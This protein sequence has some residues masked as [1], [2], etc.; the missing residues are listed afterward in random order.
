[1]ADCFKSIELGFTSVSA[2]GKVLAK[3]LLLPVTVYLAIASIIFFGNLP[4]NRIWIAEVLMVIPL[5]LVAVTTHRIVIMGAHSVPEWGINRFGWRE[6]KFTLSQIV[7][8]VFLLPVLLLVFIPYI[9]IFI[10]T[11]AGAFFVSRMSLVFPSI[12]INRKLDFKD[13]WDATKN[14]KLMMFVTVSVFPFILGV[15]EF[16][17][18][19]IQESAFV[20]Q[21]LSF[22]ATIYV[23][24]ALSIA[25]QI[26]MEPESVR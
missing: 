26:I 13:S 21:V 11:L 20:L 15:F 1:M 12:A 3:A 19:R 24:A 9:G 2:N 6:I 22:L 25:Y 8:F 16:V 7:I 4:E 10:A 23:I 18:G 5:T 17:L 14:H